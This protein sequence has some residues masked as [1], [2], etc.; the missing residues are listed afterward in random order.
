MIRA[1]MTRLEKQREANRRYCLRHP[2]REKERSRRRKCK[3][4]PGC[5]KI[6]YK[7]SSFCQ[8]CAKSGKN[9]PIYR[10]K[11]AAKKISLA[12][13]IDRLGEGNPAWRG[14]ARKNGGYIYI[15][16]PNHPFANKKRYVHEHRLVMERQLGRC[17]EPKERVHHIN[18]IK[19]DN[20]FE[21]LLLCSSM[22]EHMKIHH[23]QRREA[24]S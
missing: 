1:S 24:R 10:N 19:N 13:K 21:N 8:S 23:A 11:K 15:Y 18:G 9:N 22:G 12:L 3:P 7:R 16:S 4:C 6:I 5:G 2:D 20:R 17:L 14:G